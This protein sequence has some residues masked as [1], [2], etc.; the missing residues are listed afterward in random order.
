MR[1]IRGIKIDPK[2]IT[3]SGRGIEQIEGI[4]ILPFWSRNR[5]ADRDA[6]KDVLFEKLMIGTSSELTLALTASRR[7]HFSMRRS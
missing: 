7:V 6:L 3:R 4:A 1:A 5:A 2:S